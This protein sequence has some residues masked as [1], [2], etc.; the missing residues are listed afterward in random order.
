MARDLTTAVTTA[1]T[2]S[3]LKTVTM[4]NLQ[5][6]STPIYV[7][8]GVGTITYD[9]N[10]YLGVGGLGKVTPIKESSDLE[11]TRV[12]L[13]LS[14]IDASN[15]SVALNQ[16]YQ[17]RV[18]TIY[19]AFLDSDYTLIADPV[20]VFKGTMDNQIINLGNTAKVEVAVISLLEDWQKARIRRYNNEDQ[21]NLYPGDKG[22]E[23]V[24]QVVEKE[25]F[26]GVNNG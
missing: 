17:G 21:Q 14:G 7:H 9:G 24:E 18:A 11:V 6:D 13:E 22:L 4:V 2:A 1:S 12:I 26:W 23:F 5:F 3:T 16:Q 8:T 25:I 20:V 15:I 10:D 19:Q